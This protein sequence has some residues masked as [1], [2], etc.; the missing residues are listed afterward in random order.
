MY[1][2]E[3]K[4][5]SCNRIYKSN[6]NPQHI[7]ICDCGRV[8]IPLYSINIRCC[9][10]VEIEMILNYKSSKLRYKWITKDDVLNVYERLKKNQYGQYLKD[11]LDGKYLDAR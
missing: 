5:P 2:Y 4:C 6:Q 3:Y 9:K 1:K 8:D 10:P 11:V 7:F